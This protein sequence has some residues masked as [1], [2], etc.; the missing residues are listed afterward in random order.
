MTNTEST[1]DTLHAHVASEAIDCDGSHSRNYTYFMTEAQSVDNCGD[2]D[3]QNEVFC[4]TA[5]PFAVKDGNVRI[6]EYGFTFS[7]A[8]EEGGRSIEVVWCR[9]DCPRD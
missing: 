1:P 8:T 6:T 2:I 7:E 5:S 9:E 3:F 4:L